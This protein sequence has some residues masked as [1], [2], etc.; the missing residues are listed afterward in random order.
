HH[1]SDVSNPLWVQHYSDELGLMQLIN[2]FL[3]LKSRL[4]T[5]S[6]QFLFDWGSIWFEDQTMFNQV[7]V[8]PWHIL[9]GPGKPIRKVSQNRNYCS[10]L[11]RAK[12]CTNQ[13]IPR[14][15]LRPYVDIFSRL[16]DCSRLFIESLGT[17][18]IHPREILFFLI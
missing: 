9:I 6:P 12:V 18:Y 1:G 8:Q 11:S 4:G 17:F 13:D 7:S 3:D 5:E 10:L 15:L 14:L 2:L 16:I